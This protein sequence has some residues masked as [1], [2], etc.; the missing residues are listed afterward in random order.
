MQTAQLSKNLS[1]AIN[2]LEEI[3][4]NQDCE[5]VLETI[6]K[7]KEMKCSGEVCH[8]KSGLD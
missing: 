2:C 7:Y 8:K 6:K 3:L 5:A 1:L 4:N